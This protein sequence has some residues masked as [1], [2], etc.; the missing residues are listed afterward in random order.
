MLA[1][2]K[3]DGSNRNSYAIRRT[4]YPI[5]IKPKKHNIIS[6]ELSERIATVGP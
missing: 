5:R 2:E 4:V 6:H 1:A 3:N